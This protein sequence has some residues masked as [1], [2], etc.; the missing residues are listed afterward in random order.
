MGIGRVT[1][2]HLLP[3]GKSEEAGFGLYSYLLFSEG[4]NARNRN[5]YLKVIEEIIGQ[6]STLPEI[7]AYSPDK[8]RINVLY[9]PVRLATDVEEKSTAETARVILS[10]YDFA[11]A[12]LLLSSIDS[13]YQAGPYFVSR[14]QPL[15][16]KE[17]VEHPYLFQDLS[18]VS[19]TL[20]GNCVKRFL[21]QA[22][23]EEPWDESRVKKFA[24]SLRND[25]QI[26]TGLVVPIL[27]FPAR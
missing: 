18:A 1:G 27:W 5:R 3:P 24:A 6:V 14:L 23:K 15:S 11:R 22:A 8:K 7:L 10:N 4:E 25:I 12:R 2:R 26:L 13:K 16:V 20:I 19:P 9:I 21:R 17:R